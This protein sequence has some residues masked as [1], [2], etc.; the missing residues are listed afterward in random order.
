[1]LRLLIVDRENA[2]VEPG[3]FG[4]EG[5][6]TLV[7]A[8]LAEAE[9]ALSL[10]RFDAVLLRGPEP[11]E[12]V[13]EFV[14]RLRERERGGDTRTPVLR[15]VSAVGGHHPGIDAVLL[16][17]FDLAI[18]RQTVERL[19]QT[20]DADRVDGSPRALVFPPFE[21]EAFAAHLGHDASLI[22]EIIDL[23]FVECGHQLPDLH[24]QIAAA[25]YDRVSRIAH[26]LK[27][28]LASL[29]APG[30]RMLAQ[31]LEEAAKRHDSQACDATLERLESSI[32]G[33][34]P[35][36]LALRARNERLL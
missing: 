20:A 4:P 9:E 26:T 16:E 22:I 30:P 10:Q 21:G 13:P 29:Q 24:A 6:T 35:G 28:S 11:P 8:S 31:Q 33:M 14:S 25:D 17:H 1:M 3:P 32:E 18:L 15:A 23:F 7:T 27:G 36:L 19:N 2:G 5:T 12:G 34:R